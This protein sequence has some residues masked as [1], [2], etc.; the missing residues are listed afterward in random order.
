MASR[1]T[2]C[3][4]PAKRGRAAFGRSAGYAAG[5]SGCAV[6]SSVHTLNDFSVCGPKL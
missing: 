3:S 5:R 2:L 6:A 1:R 4:K